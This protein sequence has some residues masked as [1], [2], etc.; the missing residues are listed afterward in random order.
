MVRLELYIETSVWGFLFE[1]NI[2][3]K[4]KITEEF[5]EKVEQKGDMLYISE[6]VL[7]ELN[8]I[9]DE[10]LK[11][12]IM[13]KIKNISPHILRYNSEIEDLAKKIIEMSTIPEKFVDDAR[14][15]GY[16]IFYELD[17]VISW[18]MR[19]IVKFST[20]KIVEAVCLLS[21]FKKIEVLTPEEV[22]YEF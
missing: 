5:F 21:G 22:L 14:H 15:I 17:G 9:P 12:K 1:K 2:P 16:A 4:K 11:I 13:D 20:R 7:F 3:E 19:H 18:N 6:L 8:R 10:N